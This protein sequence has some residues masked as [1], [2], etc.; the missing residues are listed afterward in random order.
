M[1]QQAEATA[2]QPSSESPR[3][4][5]AGATGRGAR[6]RRRVRAWPWLAPTLVLV[7]VVVVYPAVEMVRTSL[8]DISSIGLAQ[9][10][11]GLDN[12][13]NLFGEPALGGVIANT[14]T[15]VVVVVGV[16]ILVSLAL[17]Q[18]LNKR[19][20]GRSLVRWALIVP[21][22]S[23]L[24][25]TATVWRYIYERDYGMLNRVL[26]DLGLID[27]PVDWFREPGVVLWCLILIGIIVSIPFATYV[28]LAGLQTIPDDLYEAARI[29]GAG[30]WQ[31]YRQITFPLLRPALLVALVLNVIYVFNS[32]PIIW[33]ITGKLP[34]ND[35][36]TT[37]TLMY[38]I[39]FTADLD[40][41]KAAALAVVNVAFLLAVVTFYLRKVRWDEEDDGL[42]QKAG[43][44]RRG[45]AAVLDRAAR[46]LRPVRSATDTLLRGLG[47]ALGR[48]WRPVR[49]VGL[50]VVGLGIAVFFLTPYAV[51]V[52]SALK[53]DADL[54]HSPA[55][56]F[57]SNWEW[58]NFAK[59]W[60]A[61]PLADYLV[62]SLVIAVAATVIVLCVSLPAA[63]FVARQRF[64]GRK[65]FL[66]V[67]LVTQM[68]APV[69]LVVGI[70]REVVLADTFLA[71][72][73]PDWSA[74]NTFWA[75]IL[76][77]A[78]FNLAFSV[79]ILNGY[80]ASIPKEIEEAAMVDGLNR[81]RAMIHVV[82]PIAKPGIVTA[83]IFTFIQVWNE[84]VVARTIFNDPTAHKQ[85]LTVGINQF[86]GLYETQYQYL[87]VASLVGIV[88]VVLLFGMI[89]RY[90]VSG[91]TAGSIK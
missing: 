81:L 70:Y 58:A 20:V 84:F 54:F 7:T 24:V 13:T 36:D 89:E 50:S 1:T 77:N 79:W 56:Y 12:Y 21:W 57:P 40:P 16:T 42:R 23:S 33:I 85:T 45:A 66:Y 47:T 2:R 14:V 78:V 67:V 34:G 22:A 86:V 48:M 87:F 3:G 41:G 38:K 69:A 17:A 73:D 83:V 71:R 18:L 35:A 68:F 28:F 30:P 76:I 49:P 25:M 29:D 80:F 61:I 74:I 10:F 75:I 43:P 46:L 52:T 6:R 53:S 15:W 27:A 11:A 19:F 44:L 55:L 88:P 72:V 62:A 59:V 82:L 8:L 64:R 51:M 91:L 63:Y 32:F 65:L 39:A 5:Q 26:L 31:T 9:G 4:S 90:L 37:V 60:S